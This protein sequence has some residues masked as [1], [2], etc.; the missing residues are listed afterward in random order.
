M[1]SNVSLK[2]ITGIVAVVSVQYYTV[3][4]REAGW[5]GGKGTRRTAGRSLGLTINYCTV[6]KSDV[7]KN[8]SHARIRRDRSKIQ[9][10][11]IHRYRYIDIAL[12]AIRHCFLSLSLFLPILQQTVLIL[13]LV[14]MSDSMMEEG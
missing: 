10:T 11:R 14:L 1:R 2:V 12:E 9:V 6:I 7:R 4:E 13:I 5:G 3:G 8:R